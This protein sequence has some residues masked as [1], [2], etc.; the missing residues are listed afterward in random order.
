MTG[1][2]Y[3]LLADATSVL[4]LLV[5]T[6]RWYGRIARVALDFGFGF[7]NLVVFYFIHARCRVSRISNCSEEPLLISHSW[8]S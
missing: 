2:S 1:A 7:A 4:A 6:T 8:P 5:A 3:P